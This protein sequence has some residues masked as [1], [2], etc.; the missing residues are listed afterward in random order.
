MPA[1][2]RLPYIEPN[3]QFDHFD[4]HQFWNRSRAVTRETG[5]AFT[6]YDRMHTVRRSAVRSVAAPPFAANDEQLANVIA[7]RCWQY[8]HGKQDMPELDKKQL[9]R[10][11]TLKVNRVKDERRGGEGSDQDYRHQVHVSNAQRIGYAQM[12]AAVA[13]RSWRLNQPSTDV[14]AS[15]GITPWNVR[16]ILWRLTAVARKLGYETIRRKH[17]GGK[18]I[19]EHTQ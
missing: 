8:C 14:A 3:S 7:H 6:D 19:L 10:I 13:Y 2:Q 12:Q 17:V 16:I 4:L 11:V 9:K 15:L 18:Y 1:V 5:I